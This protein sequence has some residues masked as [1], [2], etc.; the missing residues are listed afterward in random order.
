MF[1]PNVP[2]LPN[3]SDSDIAKKIEEL[4]NRGASM[5]QHPAQNQIIMLIQHYTAELDK[6]KFK[7][8]Q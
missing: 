1:H 2:D 4:Y 7:P 6:R 5:R 8:K 3:L